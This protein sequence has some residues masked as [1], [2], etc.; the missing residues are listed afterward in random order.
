MYKSRY[1]NESELH[2]QC[3][4]LVHGALHGHPESPRLWSKLIDGIIKEL[5]L[6]PCHHKPCLYYTNDIFG[7]K[8]I[9]LLLR[10]VDDFVV[11]CEYKD[12]AEK[13]IQAIDSKMTIKIKI[14]IC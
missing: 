5:S 3:V 9:V 7:A 14:S 8:K 6:Q 4:L 2:E 11:A 1:R 10:E 13:V 12:T